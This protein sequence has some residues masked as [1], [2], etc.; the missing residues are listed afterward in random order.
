MSAVVF[1]FGS[2]AVRDPHLVARVLDQLVVA[3]DKL[4][5]PLTELW[6]GGALGA[7]RLCEAWGRARG[8]RVRSFPVTSADW[9]R[10]PR[11]AGILRSQMAPPDA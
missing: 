4:A 6:S 2:R 10:Y 9:A 3:C 8:L 11:Q 1:A 7:D 5:E